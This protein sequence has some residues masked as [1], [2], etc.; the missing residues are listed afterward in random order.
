MTPKSLGY[1]GR[2]FSSGVSRFS[3]VR[4]DIKTW[5]DLL[6]FES[7]RSALKGVQRAY[8]GYPIRPGLLQATA[9]FAYAA[10]E[11]GVGLS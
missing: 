5:F 11:A 10:K 1:C 6:D 4:E 7:V 2:F 8:F 9:R 3:K